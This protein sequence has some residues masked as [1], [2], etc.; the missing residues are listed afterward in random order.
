MLHVTLL[1]EQAITDDGTGSVRIRSSRTVALVAFLAVHA[2]SPQARQRIAGLFWPD[3]TDAQALTNLRRELHQLRHVLGDEPSLVVTQKDLCWRDTET[4]R[5]D[6]RI[7]D[8]ER[9]AALAAVAAD[10]GEGILVHATRAIAEYRGDLLPGGYDDWLLQARSELERQCVDLCDL[11]CTTRARRGDLTGAVDAARRR[12]QLQPLEEVGYRTLMLLQADLGDRAGAVSTYH[13][14]ASVL[15]RELGVVPD[16]ATQQALQRL[17]THVNSAGTGFPATGPAIGRS[18]LAAA[19]L[20]GRSAELDLLQELWRTAA[21]GR[22]GLA[23]VRGGAGVGKTRLVAE[24]AGLARL[25]GAVVASAQCFGGSGRLALAPVADWVRNP[26][27]QSATATLDPAWRAEVDKLVPSGGRGRRVAGSRAMVD[28]WQR[29]RFFE[30]LARALLAARRPTLLVLDNMQ[31]CDQETLAFLAFCLGL[32]ESA[33][34]LVAGTLRD[35]NV[36]DD[37]ELAG[38]TVRMRATGLL[39]EL[40]VSPLELADTAHLAALVSGRPLLQADVNLLQATTGGFPLHVIE[41]VRGSVDLGST[42]LPAAD[43]TAVLHNRLDQATPA[44]REVAGLAAAVGTNFTLD[45]LAEA[46]DLDAD[47]VVGAV[48]E[49]WRRRIMHEFRDGYDFSHDL[50]R[51]TAYSQV[52]PPKRWLLHRRIAQALELLHA[53]NMEPVSAQLAEQYAR[54]GRPGRAVAYYRRAADVAAGMFAHAEAIRLHKEA[55]S[56]VRSL[57]EG[58][59]RDRQ[60]LA[61]LEAMAAPL[62]ARFGYSSPELQQTLERSVDLAESLG[63][64]DSTLTGLVALSGSRFVQGRTA[65]GYQMARRALT[66]VDPEPEL[67]GP[68]H[69]MVGGSAVSL[70]MP[71]EGLHH[72]ELA[73]NLASGALSLSI[74]T[75][76]DVHGT[77]WAAHAHWLL[78]HDAE[79]LSSCNDA[80]KLARAIDHPYSLA[81]ALAYGAITR[82][83]RHDVSE[84]RDTVSELRELCERYGFAYYRDWALVLDGWSRADESGIGL[85]RRGIDNLQSEGSFARMPYWL[86][87]LADLLVQNNR[88]GA[89]RA[90]LD[91]AMVAGQARDDLWWLPEVMRMRAAH[92]DAEAASSRLCS[93]AQMAAAHGSVALLRRCERDLAE[94]GIRLSVPGVL[95]AFA[96]R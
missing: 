3:S 47:T 43:L 9:K 40:S 39:T 23:L 63:R 1:G 15:E 36:D 93:A 87:L 24:V 5:V 6:V 57:P 76:P 55:L 60:E 22:P 10:D 13:H 65:D 48:D 31:W 35:D 75:R 58:K 88:P 73:T 12:V 38:W 91:A 86:S 84:L 29:H 56:I 26:A 33:Q 25:E 62:T 90:T 17:I 67:S 95:P 78:G 59:D 41:A 16:P 94:R 69:F 54:G 64:L 89:A 28:A 80:I 68:A 96:G 51:E 52:S 34:I 19:Q 81:V 74:G 2:G 71:A 83:V 14:C 49:L 7:F 46:S 79:A 37:R 20:V 4:C 30:G 27:V 45:L 61:V 53:D 66:L 42:P 82:Q 50:L 11:V 92:D 85:A 77:A 72:L 70:G 21:A 18:G 44:A 8:I 32:S